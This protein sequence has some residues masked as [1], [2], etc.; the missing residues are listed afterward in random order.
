VVQAAV[1]GHGVA[2]GWAPLV[3]ELLDRGALVIAH[4]RPV[5]T[6]RGYFLEAACEERPH[7]VQA[8]LRDWLLGE[9]RKAQGV[10]ALLEGR[11]PREPALTAR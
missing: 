3:D 2:L 1:E 4:D 8:L 9:C 7:G 6:G 11:A 5:Q 10:R